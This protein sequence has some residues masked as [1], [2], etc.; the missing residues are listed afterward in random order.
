MGP[1]A[2][3]RV[4]GQGRWGA[5]YRPSPRAGIMGDYNCSHDPVF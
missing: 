5:F 4:G 3:K 1:E 2:Q